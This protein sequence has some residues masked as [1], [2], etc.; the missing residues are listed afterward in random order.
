MICLLQN[1]QKFF[2]LTILHQYW[3]WLIFS[4]RY[5]GKYFVMS[6]CQYLELF[7]KSKPYSNYY[8]FCLFI[9]RRLPVPIIANFFL[10]ITKRPPIQII[11]KFCLFI[12]KRPPAQRA[13][14][15]VLKQS[16]FLLDTI[17]SF[18]IFVAPLPPCF[19]LDW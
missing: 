4:Y 17:W 2:D 3:Q 18:V 7:G 15:Q 16:C 6:I 12:R 1:C 11:A 5:I 14:T 13:P 9:T 10:F 8:I 19:I